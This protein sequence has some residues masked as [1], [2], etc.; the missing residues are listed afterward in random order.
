MLVLSRFRGETIV[1]EDPAWGYQIEISLE[2]FRRAK[3]GEPAALLGFVAPA[4]V[5]IWRKELGNF[6]RGQEANG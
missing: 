5:V 3:H 2:Q 4:D 6:L 1:L